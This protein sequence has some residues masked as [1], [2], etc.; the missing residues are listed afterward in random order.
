[1]AKKDPFFDD[2]DPEELIGYNFERIHGQPATATEIDL[3]QE[4]PGEDVTDERLRADADNP[5]SWLIHNK[6]F[7]QQGYSPADRIT[8]ENADLTHEYTLTDYRG[9]QNQPIVVPS[10]PP[11]LYYTNAVPQRVTAVNARSGED[12]WSLTYQ[13]ENMAGLTHANRGVAVYQDKVYLGSHDNHLIAIDRYNGE[14]QWKTQTYTRLQNARMGAPERMA[15]TQAPEVFDGMVFKG[16]TGFYGG[17]GAYF[18]LD[19]ETGAIVWEQTTIPTDEWIGDTWRWGDGAPWNFSAI[20]PQSRT[21]FIPTGNPSPMFNANVRPGM[22]RDSN[23]VIAID[24]DTGRVE[25]KTQLVAHDWH[26]YDTYNTHVVEMEIDGQQ[27]RVVAAINKTGWVYFLDVH[28]GKLVERTEPYSLQGGEVDF[29]GRLP[30]G[31]GNEESVFPS[32]NGATE[33][34]P[35]AF[36]PDTGYMYLGGQDHGYDYAAVDYDYNEDEPAIQTGGSKIGLSEDWRDEVENYIVAIN[37]ATGEVEWK[38]QYE[39]VEGDPGFFARSGGV[40]VTGGNVAFGGS[41]DG[42]LVALNAETGDHLW[43]DKVSDTFRGITAAPM[44][45]DDMGEEKQYVAI[46]SQDGIA[47]YSGD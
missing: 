33:W 20:D 9:F 7:E 23:S 40:T 34:T 4:A 43:E 3:V 44:T 26:D 38:H 15:T 39:T 6:G 27:R 47:V 12:L 5:E 41:S 45:W 32:D 25:W 42:K 14:I 17:W 16:Q 35:D 8:P 24:V 30:Y 46:A 10:D 2:V 21:I 13:N 29:M 19:A 28:S 18:G 31:E 22:N 11:V 37:P 36:S 1:M